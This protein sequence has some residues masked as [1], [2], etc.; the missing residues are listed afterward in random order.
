V[1]C[2][3]KVKTATFSP[4]YEIDW[5]ID[6]DKQLLHLTAKIDTVGWAAI[7]W[8]DQGCGGPSCQGMA[9]A[10]FAIAQFNENGTVSSMMR[11]K[12]ELE[13][14]ANTKKK[15]KRKMG[16]ARLFWVSLIRLNPKWINH[17][18]RSCHELQR[19][20]KSFWDVLYLS[21]WSAALSC[22]FFNPPYF[23]YS[24]K[25]CFSLC[26]NAFF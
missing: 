3:P 22:L 8:H 21:F 18:D 11:M 9:N 20:K 10:D 26:L 5:M 14:R 24:F 6:E 4:D 19:M 12:N 1:R 17:H 23:F 2:S 13:Q 15:K 7:G 25:L 16:R